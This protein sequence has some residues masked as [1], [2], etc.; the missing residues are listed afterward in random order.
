MLRPVATPVTPFADPTLAMKPDFEDALRFRASAS[1]ELLGQ[2]DSSLVE[3]S[4]TPHSRLLEN[5]EPLVSTWF[6]LGQDIDGEAR[7]DDSGRSVSLSSDGKTVAIGAPDNDGNAYDAGHVRVW[8]YDETGLKWTQLGQDI[9]GEARSDYS[10][11]SVSLSSDGKTVA[12]GAPGNDGNGN[13][14][15]HV[16]V[17]IYDQTG[18]K[19]TQLGQ[20]IDGEA[21]Y[22]NSGSSVSLSSDGKIVAIGASG[23]DGNGDKAG[24]VRVWKYDGI[25]LKWTQLG[26]DIDGEAA[27]D[28]SGGLLIADYSGGPVSLSSDGE[29]VAIGAGENDGNA[30]DAGH[31]RVWKYDGILLKWTQLGQD[32][33]G[34]A[35]RDNSGSSVSLSSDGKTVAIGAIMNDGNGGDAGHVRV[36]IYDQTEW[37][38]TQLGQDIDGEAVGD[39]SGHSVSLSSDGKTV[40]IGASGNDGNGAAGHVRVWKYDGILLK[41]TQLGQDIDGEAAYDNSGRSVSLSSDGK[42]VAIGA[43]GNDGNDDDA[44]HVRIFRYGVQPPEPTFLPSDCPSAIPSALPSLSPSAIPTS[45]PSLT[46]SSAPTISALPTMDPSSASTIS[47]LLTMILILGTFV[48]GLII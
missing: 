10:G 29:T 1:K 39:F 34:E 37:K 27:W 16:R 12:I 21:A 3:T 38:W 45:L 46:P 30:Y 42:T 26:Q 13:A 19:W 41:W 5:T 44:G 7:R 20:D 25:L 17:W 47:A 2:V 48:F 9:D 8:E 31:V 40:A 23:N 22:D 14:A 18:L 36:W 43:P 4:L 24:H 6:Q 28:L 11:R 35:R 33:D 32:I 15:G